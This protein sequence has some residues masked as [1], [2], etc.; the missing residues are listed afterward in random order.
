MHVCIHACIYV[1]FKLGFEWYGGNCPTW[2]G[3]LSRGNC[4][5]GIFRRGNCPGEMFVPPHDRTISICPTVFRLIFITHSIT[6]ALISVIC[7]AEQTTNFLS[8]VFHQQE[9]DHQPTDVGAEGNTSAIC[10]CLLGK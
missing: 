3:E 6:H 10:V 2:E 8:F 5:R 7:L 9:C 1:I 4:P